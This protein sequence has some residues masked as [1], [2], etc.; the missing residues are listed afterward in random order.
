MK[1]LTQSWFGMSALKAWFTLSS[2]HGWA[3]SGLVVTTFLPRTTPCNPIVFISRSTVRAGQS[4]VLRGGEG[5]PVIGSRAARTVPNL[6][7]AITAPAVIE[8][9]LEG[10]QVEAILFGPIRCQGGV[11]LPSLEAVEC[12]WCDPQNP[13]DRPDTMDTTVIIDKR[14]HLRNGRSSSAAAKYALAFFRISLAWR[15]SRTS[16]SS[17]LILSFSALVGPPR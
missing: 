17:S 10:S 6:A 11:S 16:R 14:D 15:N 1:S 3:I 8:G 13:A 4:R 2:G 9:L 5:K 7:R 12:R